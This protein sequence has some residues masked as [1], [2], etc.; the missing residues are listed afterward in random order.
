[1]SAIIHIKP[2]LMVLLVF[3][4]ILVYSVVYSFSVSSVSAYSVQLPN[5]DFRPHINTTHISP[6]SKGQSNAI[7]WGTIGT[8]IGLGIVTIITFGTTAELTIPAGVGII[9][10]GAASGVTGYI[11]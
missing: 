3:Y 10:L 8:L 9:G 6:E 11:S 5:V 1:M 2:K 7:T 4:L